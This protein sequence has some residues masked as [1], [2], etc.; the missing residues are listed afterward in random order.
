MNGFLKLTADRHRGQPV[1]M[2]RDRG[3]GQRGQ[4]HDWKSLHLVCLNFKIEFRHFYLQK[5]GSFYETKLLF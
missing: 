1:Q 3:G 5:T 4:G 2:E